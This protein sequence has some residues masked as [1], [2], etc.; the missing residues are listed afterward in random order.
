MFKLRYSTTSPFARKVLVIAAETGQDKEIELVKTVTADPASDIGKDNPLNKVP[1]LVLEDGSTLYDS[2]VICEFLDSRHRGAKLF[3]AT[4]PARWTALRREALAD[5][6]M[7]AGV[8]CMMEIRR[9]AQEQSSAWIARQKQKLAQGVDALEREALSFGTTLDIGLFTIAIAFGY[10]DFRFKADDWR[11]GHPH[12]A[13][14]YQKIS[15][16][17]SLQN[18]QPHD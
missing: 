8:L 12:L 15:A 14:W 9:P 1:T 6:M 13:D 4:G 7:D 10:L 3:P 18:T 11:A 17:P 5:G 2:H 16:R